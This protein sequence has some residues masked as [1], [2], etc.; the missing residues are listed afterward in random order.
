VAFLLIIFAVCVAVGAVAG[1]IIALVLGLIFI[2]SG[3]IVFKGIQIAD[4]S[5]SMLYNI[6]IVAAVIVAGIVAGAFAGVFLAFILFLIILFI[7]LVI[8]GAVRLLVYLG[9]LT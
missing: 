1:L 9:F 4:K 6:L 8:N 2:K 3:K 7:A 5:S